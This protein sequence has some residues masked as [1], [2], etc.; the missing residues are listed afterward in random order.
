MQGFAGLTQRISEYQ[1][2]RE[3]RA[4]EARA[5]EAQRQ[6]AQCSFAP[7]INRQRVVATVSQE[8]VVGGGVGGGV[9]G[10]GEP[11]LA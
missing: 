8:G 11:P 1:A 5:A 4:A 7:A 2:E 10:A 9:G 6:L 3:A